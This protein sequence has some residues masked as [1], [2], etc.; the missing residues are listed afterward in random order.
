MTPDAYTI[1]E[2]FIE[3]GDGHTLYVHDWGNKDAETP[4][5]FLH[6]GPGGQCGDKHKRQFDAATQRVIFFD[7][8]GS[9]KSLPYGSLEHNTT[10]DMIHDIGAIADHFNIESFFLTGR[11]WGSCLALAYAL[12][13]PER[14][15]AMV[16]GGIFTGSQSEIDWLDNGVFATFYPEAWERYLAATPESH[17]NNPGEYHYRRLMGTDEAAAKTSGLAY[18]T[19]EGS[20]MQL[21]DSFTPPSLEEY[22]PAPIRIEMHYMHERCFL[23]DRFILKSAHKLAMPIYLVQGR[24]DMVCPPVT[25]YELNE[26]L[27]NSELYMYIGGHRV[28]HESWNITKA[29]LGRLT[30]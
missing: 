12:E 4:I 1:Q 11:S 27:P 19:L 26:Y 20:V 13:H 10:Q 24:Y 14:V 2:T 21:D 17:R 3:V 30:A 29:L 8:R 18:D 23:P 15:K 28:E 25:A 5:I 16:L 22:D 7:Q 9:G 6:G